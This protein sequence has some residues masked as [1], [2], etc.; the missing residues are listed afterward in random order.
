MRTGGRCPQGVSRRNQAMREVTYL[1]EVECSVDAGFLDSLVTVGVGGEDGKRQFLQANRN[2]V[3][4]QGGKHYLAVGVVQVDY[5]NRRVLIELP[6][7]SDAGV[8][9]LWVPF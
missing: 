2:L 3:T 5:R 7:E 6:H 9:R 1:P 4:S 8:N